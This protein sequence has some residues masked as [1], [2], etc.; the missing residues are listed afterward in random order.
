MPSKLLIWL[1][2]I[3]PKFFTATIIPVI[4]GA[5]LG[6]FETGQFNWGYFWLTML[7][8][9]LCHTGTNLANDYFDHTSGNDWAN[10]NPTPFSGG[11]RMIQNKIIPPRQILIASLIAFTIGSLVGLYLNAVTG[12][13]VIL[14]IGI[15][16]VFLGF[17]YTG[18][19]LRIGY[20]GFGVGEIAVGL[21]FGPLVV[22]GA[23][24]VQT[25]HLDW[26]PLIASVPVAILIAL[27]LYI[28]EFPDYEADKSVRKITLPVMI[29]KRTA[30]IIY[31][32]LLALVY[33]WIGGGVLLR[34]F[35]PLTLLTLL[36]LPIAVKAVTTLY[37]HYQSIDNI[38]PANASTI[39]LH[40]TF[41]II[42][43]L[44]FFLNRILIF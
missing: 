17:F 24:Y 41:G 30:A 18:A 6:W 32:I 14:I 28:N 16:G 15:I 3:R 21:G 39:A 10:Q 1:K 40:L 20:R 26:L 19:P 36:T 7:G 13:R 22:I 29:G 4:L 43:S 12:G 2:A 35:P 25:R 34:W 8:I 38:L 37:R 33:L 31:C 44:S 9:V 42:F 27:V 5:L 11:S 23:Y